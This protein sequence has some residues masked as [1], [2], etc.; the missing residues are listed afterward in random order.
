M[1]LSALFSLN[2]TH[3]VRIG[4]DR[5]CLRIL[6]ALLHL[7]KQLYHSG[8]TTFAKP[9]GVEVD[10]YQGRGADAIADANQLDADERE[11]ERRGQDDRLKDG[12]G[13]GGSIGGERGGDEIRGPGWVGELGE[14]GL[15][16][17]KRGE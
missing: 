17:G 10:A 6:V 14:G 16:R 5:R 8:S 4:V 9:H 7:G 12:G 15:R 3:W 1:L 11:S 2:V 13:R